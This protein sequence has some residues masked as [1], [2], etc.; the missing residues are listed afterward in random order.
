M[1]MLSYLS[2]HN[3]GSTWYMIALIV[4][5]VIEVV[6]VGWMVISTVKDWLEERKKNGKS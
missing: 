6:A 2:M 5:L 3:S 1:P 4:L